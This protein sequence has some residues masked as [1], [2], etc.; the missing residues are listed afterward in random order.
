M[1]RAVIAAAFCGL[2]VS[3]ANA[4][5]L[6][7][8]ASKA[9][10]AMQA[11]AAVI[12]PWTGAYIGANVG[13]SWGPWSASSN[14]LIFNFESTTARPHVNGVIGG[15]QFGYN[16]HTAPQWVW[17][18]E[19]DIQASGEKASQTWTD[20]ELP[21]TTIP[22]I[23]DF[24]PRAGGPA[25]LSHTWKFPWFSTLRLRAGMLASPNWLLYLTGGVAIGESKYTFDFSQPGAAT[26]SPPSPTNYSLSRSDTRVGGTVGAGSEFKLSSTTSVKFEYLYI[27]LGKVTINTTDIDGLPFRVSYHVRDHV[28][29]V[30]LNFALGQP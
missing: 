22:V 7:V 26:N 3:Y 2:G 19:A 15:L 8:K 9:P 25:V 10:L 18:F 13:Y 24:V 30:G 14:Q 12:D 28:A 6:P 17:G 23:T 29:R 5:D 20:P 1:K 27:D 4:A 16:W 11:M 21:P